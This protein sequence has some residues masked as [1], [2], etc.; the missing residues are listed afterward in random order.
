MARDVAILVDRSCSMRGSALPQARRAVRMI[1]DHLGENDAVQVFAFDHDRI[2]ADGVGSK[3]MDISP[4]TIHRID[5][6]LAGLEA[7]GGTELDEAL[8]RVM[9]LPKRERRARIVVLITDAAVGNEGRL[10]RRI[11]E[12]MGD[13][14]LYVLG[15]GVAVNRYL[16]ARLARAG[17]GAS[18]VLLPHEDVETVVPRFARRVRQAGPV[19]EE[20]QLSW[21]DALPVDVYPNPIPPLFGGQ[22]VQLLGRYNGVGESTLVLT[23]TT[24][25][26]EP[27]RQEIPVKLPEAANMIPGL[28]R[29]WARQRID[30]LVERLESDPKQAGEVRMEVLGLALRHSLLSPYTSLVAEDSEKRVD[31]EAKRVEVRPEAQA[32]GPPPPAPPRGVAGFIRSDADDD[33]EEPSASERTLAGTF[34]GGAMDMDWL[35]SSAPASRAPSPGGPPMGGAPPP[36]S[37]AAPIPPPPMAAAMPDAPLRAA[38]APA[39]VV[40]VSSLP[41]G[42]RK[43]GLGAAIGKIFGMGDD[44]E[45]EAFA[46]EDH[47]SIAEHDR[48]FESLETPVPDHYPQVSGQPEPRMYYKAD[49]YTS[50]MLEYVKGKQIGELDLVFLVDETGSMGRYIDQVKSRL[51]EIIATLERSPLCRSLRL[52]LVSYRDHPPQDNTFASRVVPLTED[53]DAIRKGVNRMRAH[54]GGD[55]PESVT[56]GLYDVARLDWRPRAARVVVL[57]GDAPPHGVEPSGDGFPEG[58]PCG[59]HWYT[60]AENCREMGVV[61]HAVGCLP[62]IQN[63]VGAEGVFKQVAETTH[64]FYLPLTE[65]KVLIPLITGVAESDLDRQRIEEHIAEVLARYEAMLRPA[66]QQERIRFVTD[67]LQ[68]SNV[69]PR[70][71]TYDQNFPGNSSLTFRDVT[72]IDVAAGFEQLRRLKR[73]TL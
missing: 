14:R 25:L 70:S 53:V 40:R 15:L 50:E 10:L 69:Q 18:D 45:E 38:K 61:I 13:T 11:P 67:V 68:Q 37:P 33:L 47:P 32:E 27:F 26:G 24:A 36:P 20:L 7:R 46:V 35:A 8:E 28:E 19:L 6:L 23:G 29:L 62:G 54:G 21:D 56:D 72:I 22:T 66:D 57:V 43:R 5:E 9:E 48:S 64:G 59:H 63:Y 41:K 31:G 49:D 44:T 16:V 1:L 17:G 55:G 42:E 4:V 52:G 12:I 71:F 51:Q 58:C 65:T 30:A 34:K 60:Q 3:Y 39:A 73:T 2:A